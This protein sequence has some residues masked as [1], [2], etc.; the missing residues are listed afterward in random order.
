[1][2]IFEYSNIGNR[3]QNQDYISHREFSDGSAVFVLCDGMGG[4]S[5]GDIAAKVVSDAIV[6]FFD[7]HRTE[8]Y[9][10]KLLPESFK[11]ANDRLMIERLGLSCKMG[12]VVVA[13]YLSNQKIYISWLGDSRAY[14]FKNGKQVYVTEDHSLLNELKHIRPLTPTEIQQYSSVVT[15]CIMGDDRLPKVIPVTILNYNAEDE[16]Y[17]CSDGIHK[18]LPL[19]LLPKESES[20]KAYLDEAQSRISDNYSLLKVTL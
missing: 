17:L 18:E 6:E 9:P 2:K 7:E 14:L 20:L 5:Y 10:H 19:E 4:Y 15:E 12:T 1:M 16:L 3:E 13:A 8:H 11:Y